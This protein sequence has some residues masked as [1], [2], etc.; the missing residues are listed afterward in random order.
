[1]RDVHDSKLNDSKLRSLANRNARSLTKL[2]M[3]CPLCGKDESEID[4]RLTDHIT[5]HL[6]SLAIISLPIHY[7]EDILGDVGSDKNGSN[8]SQPRSRSTINLLDDEDILIIQSAVD[9]SLDDIAEPSAAVDAAASDEDFVDMLFQQDNTHSDLVQHSEHVRVN[10][11][12]IIPSPESSDGQNSTQSTIQFEYEANSRHDM[13][14]DD[15][16]MSNP[17][18]EQEHAPQEDSSDVAGPSNDQYMTSKESQCWECQRHG[19]LCDGKIPVCDNCSEAGMVCPGYSNAK[20]PMWL[21]M[22]L[23]TSKVSG[24]KKAESPSGSP[25]NRSDL[26]RSDIGNRQEMSRYAHL[27]KGDPFVDNPLSSLH[28]ISSDSVVGNDFMAEAEREPLDSQPKRRPTANQLQ[29]IVL[30]TIMQRN[31]P[32]MDGKTWHSSFSVNKRM[33]KTLDLYVLQALFF[34]YRNY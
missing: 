11:T 7:D 10:K 8:S 14:S 32:P 19:T 6:R 20:P 30:Q 21:P 29:Q 31:T 5:G 2:F 22:W 16:D 1:M 18:L 3:S 12:E 23:P 4:T 24:L 15:I 33:G 28:P 9:G 27:S 25:S 26:G 17:Q 34:N 13:D